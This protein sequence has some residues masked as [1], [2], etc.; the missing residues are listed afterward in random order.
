[1]REH[2]RPASELRAEVQT[3]RDALRLARDRESWVRGELA[4]AVPGSRRAEELTKK[5]R[6]LEIEIDT[7]SQVANYAQYEAEAV[8][9]LAYALNNKPSYVDGARSR[10][11]SAF[12]SEARIKLIASGQTDLEVINTAARR[13]AE[14][15]VA[16][17]EAR[18]EAVHAAERAKET[19]KIAN[20]PGATHPQRALAEEAEKKATEKAQAL[21]HANEAYTKQVTTISVGGITL[22]TLI[23]VP[24]KAEAAREEAQKAGAEARMINERLAQVREAAARPDA[25]L[26]EL[27]TVVGA[28]F[29]AH[30]AKESAE[31]AYDK[32]VE[33]RVDEQIA[34]EEAAKVK[35][36]QEAEARGEAYFKSTAEG[37]AW[38]G[39]KWVGKGVMTGLHYTEEGL[40]YAVDGWGYMMGMP[41][42]IASPDTS[43]DIGHGLLAAQ[44]AIIEHVAAPVAI[45]TYEGAVA[46]ANPMAPLEEAR[47]RE[48]KAA[49]RFASA[50]EIR[51]DDEIDKSLQGKFPNVIIIPD[52]EPPAPTLVAEAKRKKRSDEA[53]AKI[54]EKAQQSIERNMSL[55][56]EG[57]PEGEL[58]MSVDPSS[59]PSPSTSA[60][61]V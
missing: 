14:A 52:A 2:P 37:M 33:A 25:G 3:A 57:E 51:D 58:N 32:Y 43:V 50:A 55:I 17:V 60:P 28:A 4:T 1:M 34:A 35:V 47:Q 44:D 6:D 46:E 13:V 39:M 15:R 40:A 36:E 41:N 53:W 27:V 16:L 23:T 30:A 38:E 42:P 20:R 26:S 7:H 22:A 54:E 18:I 56:A 45:A 29:K 8:E 24:S 31:R 10:T 48:E 49:E 21:E 61:K 5:L 9:D 12:E 11:A 59:A 19:R